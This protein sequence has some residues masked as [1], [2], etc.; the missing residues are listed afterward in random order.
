MLYKYKI[1]ATLA[2]MV[3]Y[4]CVMD[5]LQDQ[6]GGTIYG[7][8]EDDSDIN[9]LGLYGQADGISTTNLKYLSFERRLP[10]SN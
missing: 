2:M 1:Q 10:N 4:L 7:R 5:Y 3:F 8:Y 6:F 9:Q